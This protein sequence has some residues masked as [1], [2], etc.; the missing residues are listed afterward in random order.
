VNVSKRIDFDSRPSRRL[1]IVAQLLALLALGLGLQ[2]LWN[3]TGGTVFAFSTFAPVLTGV[4]S[5]ILIGTLIY[6]FRKR[7]SLFEKETYESGQEIFR[8]GDE[9]ECAYFIRSGEVEVLQDNKV[10]AR[11]SSG[12]Y[13][14]EMALIQDAPRN[15][16]VRAVGRT[17]VAVLGK[18]NFLTM[19]NLMPATHEDIMKTVQ[20]RALS[21]TAR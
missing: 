8:Q 17:E 12:Q 20:E 5:L 10:V 18:G 4:A 6:R 7:H 21:Q 1:L 16:T 11:L 13:F 9:G 2:F 3:T 14:G 15:A 19:L